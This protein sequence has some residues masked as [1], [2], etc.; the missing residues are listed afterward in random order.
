MLSSLLESEKFSSLLESEKYEVIFASAFDLTKATLLL[1]AALEVLSWRTSIAVW[2][3]KGGKS[4]YMKALACNLILHI[5]F[6]VPIYVFAARFLCRE[7]D[8]TSDFQWWR[9]LAVLT[10][11]SVLYYQAH[12]TFHTSPM[13]YKHVHRFHHR[14]KEHT[15]PV[16]ANAVTVPE[17]LIAYILPFAV[18]AFLLQPTLRELSAAIYVLSALNLLVHTPILKQIPGPPFWVMPSTHMDHHRFVNVH[19]ASPAWN[20][21]WMVERITTYLHQNEKSRKVT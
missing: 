9:T 21:D 11:H 18:G 19:F 20:I 8:G 7:D 16:A 5:F 4:L 15:P 3:Q 6:G 10:I 13:L 2:Q 1:T 14:F 17:Y 12:K